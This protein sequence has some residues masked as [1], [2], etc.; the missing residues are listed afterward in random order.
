M[1]DAQTTYELRLACK[2]PGCPVC[3]IVQKAGARYIEGIFSESM[4]DPGIRLK[5]VESLGFCFEHTWQ[6]IDLKLT[7][8]LGHS[9][10]FQDL[11][12]DALKKIT[13]N[14]HSS[15]QQLASLLE[16]GKDCPACLIEDSTEK[17]AI[18]S[19]S[20][21]LIDQEFVQ[22][23][24]K[25]NGLCL[26]HLR[27]LLPELN[28]KSQQVILEQQRSKLQNLANELADF[29]RKSDYRFRDEA[30]GQEGDSYKRAAEVVWGKRRP[31]NK[32][33]LL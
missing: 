5:L 27:R 19:L 15:G 4:L 24:Q 2:K 8:T 23:Y 7:E 16:P 22:E 6:S 14:G 3:A 18:Q 9:I 29:L 17:R 10:L 21:G 31:T 33:D 1:H 11:V 30:I 20:A 28:Q 26:P 13:E 32:K 25:S 12:R